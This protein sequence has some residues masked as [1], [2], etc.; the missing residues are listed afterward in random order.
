MEFLKDSAWQ[1]PI[2]LFREAMKR[3]ALPPRLRFLS[4]FPLDELTP[5]T[6][7]SSLSLT[8]NH[9]PVDSIPPLHEFYA[10]ENVRK[11]AS[12]KAFTKDRPQ[13]EKLP[14]ECNRYRI[15]H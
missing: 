4:D 1:S 5:S 9:R 7:R 10:V 3:R 13:E 2:G 11:A 6:E 14:W 8:L 15:G 12:C